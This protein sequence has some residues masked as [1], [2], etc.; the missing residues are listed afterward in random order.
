MITL[1][2]I[3]LFLCLKM[4]AVLLRKEQMWVHMIPIQISLPQHNAQHTDLTGNY[5]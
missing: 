3:D 1:D 4:K 5:T 2:K